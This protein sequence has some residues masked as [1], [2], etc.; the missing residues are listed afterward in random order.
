MSDVQSLA[1]RGPQQLLRKPLAGPKASGWGVLKQAVSAGDA[2][3]KR[4]GQKLS[5]G[6]S[7]SGVSATSSLQRSREFAN[8]Y[9]GASRRGVRNGTLHPYSFRECT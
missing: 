9:Q 8:C 4:S 5:T 1:R 7:A 3:P 6:S 2:K